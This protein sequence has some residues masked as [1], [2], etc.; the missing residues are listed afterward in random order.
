MYFQ[1]TTKFFSQKSNIPCH[2]LKSC[3]LYSCKHLQSAL[4]EKQQ[5]KQ[6]YITKIWFF[7]T[8]NALLTRPKYIIDKD[9]RIIF[10]KFC[11]TSYE[12]DNENKTLYENE[13]EKSPLNLNP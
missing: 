10:H 5:Q 3:S 7:I 4:F 1:T 6:E 12:N 2:K 11:K 8:N 13:N 9:I